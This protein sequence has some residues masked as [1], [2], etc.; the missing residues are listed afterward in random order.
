MKEAERAGNGV[1]SEWVV[2]P[3]GDAIHY[4]GIRFAQVT[5]GRPIASTATRLRGIQGKGIETQPDAR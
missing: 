3:K 1:K 4:D 2:N 5:G